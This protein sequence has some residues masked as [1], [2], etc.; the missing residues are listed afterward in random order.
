MELKG[1]LHVQTPIALI[2][3]RE[4]SAHSRH[5]PARRGF[6]STH[7]ARIAADK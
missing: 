1:A 6:V 7:A 4:Q 3:D 5:N 2:Q